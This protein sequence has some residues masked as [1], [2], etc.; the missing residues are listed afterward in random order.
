MNQILA[1]LDRTSAAPVVAAARSLAVLLGASVA[2]RFADDAG[3]SLASPLAAVVIAGCGPPAVA[4]AASLN[5]PV[6]VVPATCEP[7]PRIQ[8]ILVPLDGTPGASAASRP[9]IETAPQAGVEI[10]V[11]HAMDAETCP[12]FTDQP[13]HELTEWGHEFLARHCPWGIDAVQFEHRVGAA[14]DVIHATANDRECDAI[15][16]SWNRATRVDRSAVVRATVD[17]SRHPVLLLAAEADGV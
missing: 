14:E 15:V 5:A 1:L 13:Q 2:E 3:D 17:R 16:L 11:V 12:A 6:L 7:A 4:L 10:V 9:L 8:R